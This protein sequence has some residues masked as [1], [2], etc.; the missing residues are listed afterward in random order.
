M[1]SG[2]Y[3]Y[4]SMRFIL[5]FCQAA[6]LL[7]SNVLTV[8]EPAL[9]FLPFAKPPHIALVMIQRVR[10]TI[11]GVSRL[12]RKANVTSANCSRLHVDT[13]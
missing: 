3:S 8:L 6:V 13:F 7:G 4:T 1:L 10:L 5:H 2:Q 12:V 9:E 11:V